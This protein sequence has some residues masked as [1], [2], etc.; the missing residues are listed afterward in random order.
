MIICTCSAIRRSAHV[1]EEPT[2]KPESVS[3]INYWIIIRN[4]RSW[5]PLQ[6]TTDDN[7]LPLVASQS[8]G[9]IYRERARRGRSWAP[10][11]IL[12]LYLFRNPRRQKLLPWNILP[13]KLIRNTFSESHKLWI[14]LCIAPDRLLHSRVSGTETS[15]IHSENLSTDHRWRPPMR[16]RRT[17]CRRDLQ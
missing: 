7:C 11:E 3:C 2:R 9:R 10:P 17:S 12:L 5:R 4:R 15:W 13:V 16:P 1:T 8:V 14:R 6:D